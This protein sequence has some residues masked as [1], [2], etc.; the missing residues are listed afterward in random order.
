M[1]IYN[2][3]RDQPGRDH[4]EILVANGEWQALLTPK[5]NTMR[6]SD[7]LHEKLEEALQGLGTIEV[8]QVER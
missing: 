8:I 2:C 4:Y 7:A 1:D 5:D 3:I 6:Y